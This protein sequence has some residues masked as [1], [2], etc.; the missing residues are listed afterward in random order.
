M[1][2]SIEEQTLALAGVAQAAVLVRDLAYRGSA[3]QSA[4]EGSIRSLFAFDAEDTA[5]IFGGEA[6]VAVGLK[7]LRQSLGGQDRDVELTRYAMILLQLGPRFLQA[8]S[9]PG[10]VH[11]RLV[12]LAHDWE[13]EGLTD[14]LFEQIN[15]LYRDTISNLTPKVVVNGEQTFLEQREIA[16]QIRSALLAG[17]RAAVLWQQV[18][19]SRLQLLFR[20]KRYLEA[21]E[22]LLRR[23]M[24]TV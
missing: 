4:L 14:E 24:G 11:D 1:S 5:E 19:G 20:R 21:C 17:I 3:P 15:A 7:Q 23:S 8:G 12:A 9:M 6:G 16:A 10:R 22:T 2:H 18:G 13:R